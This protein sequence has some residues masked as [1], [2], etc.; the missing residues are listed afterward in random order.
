[1]NIGELRLAGEA[2]F[3][4][5]WQMPMARALGRLH[6]GGARDSIDIRA[7]QRWVSG[8]RPVPAWVD[9]A[10]LAE[11]AREARRAHLAAA[12]RISAFERALADE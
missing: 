7:V 9:G 8:E 5:R 10:V 1:M 12:A 4:G 6:P 2:I 3:G 11:V